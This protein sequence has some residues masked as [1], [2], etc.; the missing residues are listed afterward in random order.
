[1]QVISISPHQHSCPVPVINKQVCIQYDKMI[2]QPPGNNSAQGACRYL[3]SDSIRN[4]RQPGVRGRWSTSTGATNW[5]SIAAQIL[6]Y[7]IIW[8]DT[9]CN[10]HGWT[11]LRAKVPFGGLESPKVHAWLRPC[12]GL[13]SARHRAYDRELW[14]EIVETETLQQGQAT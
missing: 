10:A 4:R 1:M 8:F 13:W 14:R 7:S 5:P 3:L 2:S 11:L 6:V 12:L 9:A